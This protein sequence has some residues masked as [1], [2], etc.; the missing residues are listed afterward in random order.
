MQISVI[1]HW[2]T[3]WVVGKG[4]IK[5]FMKCLVCV[6]VYDVAFSLNLHLLLLLLFF[7]SLYYHWH[8]FPTILTFSFVLFSISLE[9][10][11]IH[12]CLTYNYEPH[13]W[14]VLDCVCLFNITI[15]P[16]VVYFHWCNWNPCFIITFLHWNSLA[17]F[18]S[19]TKEA[20]FMTIFLR[21][22]WIIHDRRHQT[23]T[24]FYVA[25]LTFC[26]FFPH[27]LQVR[28]VAPSIHPHMRIKHYIVS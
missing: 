8:V 5:S 10:F 16:F 7:S 12:Y 24:L 13:I 1:W 27:L 4:H 6:E 2:Q 18:Y 15:L 21:I 20:K 14:C 26:S 23:I 22:N 9:F 28:R 19:S 17:T 25:F 11:C 3:L